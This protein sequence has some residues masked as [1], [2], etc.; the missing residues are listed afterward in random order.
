MS[1][2]SDDGEKAHEGCEGY[3]EGR[4]QWLAAQGYKTIRISSTKVFGARAKVLELL[5]RNP[6]CESAA[7]KPFP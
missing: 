3:D 6:A 7:I 1:S 4:D 2:L 5:R